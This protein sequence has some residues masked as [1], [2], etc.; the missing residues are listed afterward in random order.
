VS[1]V[2]RTREGDDPRGE[3]NLFIYSKTLDR[4]VGGSD[5]ERSL[6]TSG[7]WGEAMRATIDELEALV[8][9]GRIP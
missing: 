4:R 2:G 5:G 6:R 3:I 9:S 8:A 1:P 7:D